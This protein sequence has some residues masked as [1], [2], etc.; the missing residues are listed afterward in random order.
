MGKDNDHVGLADG[1]DVSCQDVVAACVVDTVA[2]EIQNSMVATNSI[3]CHAVQ[4][5]CSIAG[6]VHHTTVCP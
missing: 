5:G 4:A 6:V 2:V 1:L 3:Y